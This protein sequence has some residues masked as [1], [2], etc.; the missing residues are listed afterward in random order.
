MR[1]AV[2][3]ALALV[4]LARPSDACKCVHPSAVGAV[5]HAKVAFVG[6]ITAI[7]GST[8][9]VTVTEVFRGTV[10]ATVTVE[11]S[12][13]SCGLVTGGADVGETW[14][15]VSKT[16][17]LRFRQCDGSRRATRKVMKRL[18]AALGAGTAPG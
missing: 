4:L 10:A 11:T 15:F 9:E 8:F 12:A 18:H 6:E 14:L 3:L 13:S 17:A 2:L 1:T 7:R 5:K 16:G